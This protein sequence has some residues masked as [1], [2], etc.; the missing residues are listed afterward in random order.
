MFSVLA[1]EERAMKAG[2]DGFIRKPL[3]KHRVLMALEEA[4]RKRNGIA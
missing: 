3:E 2:A 4:A 1:S